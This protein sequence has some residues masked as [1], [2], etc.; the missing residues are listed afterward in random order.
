MFR[1]I[2]QSLSLN[3]SVILQNQQAAFHHLLKLAD[4]IYSCFTLENL[5]EIS[6]L[7]YLPPE[8]TGQ[9]AIR[10]Y[11]LELTS[12]TSDRKSKITVV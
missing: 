9:S 12:A 4:D 3:R 11:K 1:L 6:K 10:A 5:L 7:L 2:L 8:V